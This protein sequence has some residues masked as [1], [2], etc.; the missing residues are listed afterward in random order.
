K[1]RKHRRLGKSPDTESVF[2]KVFKDIPKLDLE[3]L[4]PGARVQITKWDRSKIGFPL[5][6]GLALA[7]WKI[8]QDVFQF[9]RAVVLHPSMLWG[10]AVAGLG[11]GYKSF[12]GYQTT[13]QRYS[14]NLTQSLYYQNLDNNAGVLFRLLDE[15]E[16]QECREAIL[17]YYYLW[18]YA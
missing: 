4:L 18:R 1:Q 7:V 6:T 11:Y 9:V 5:L 17:A 16:E 14:L 2:L 12:Y 8:I 3:M 15:A 10:A 13:K